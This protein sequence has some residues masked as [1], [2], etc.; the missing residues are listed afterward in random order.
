MVNKEKSAL[1]HSSRISIARRRGWRRVSG[2]VEGQFPVCCLGAPLVNG[3][4]K[5]SL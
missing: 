1:F 2:F 4:L 3:R 5:S